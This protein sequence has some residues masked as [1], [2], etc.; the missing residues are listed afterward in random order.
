MS[1]SPWTTHQPSLP[2]RTIDH[3]TVV[4]L[5]GGAEFVVWAQ[6]GP[7]LSLMPV[8]RFAAPGYVPMAADDGTTS[9][10]IDTVDRSHMTAA[11]MKAVGHL[12]DGQRAS[13]SGELRRQRDVLRTN[14]PAAHPLAATF[15]Q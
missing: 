2:G 14:R 7:C 6:N 4:C 15:T 11:G 12:D 10:W 5:L 1:A 9:R 3:G 13:V 8:R